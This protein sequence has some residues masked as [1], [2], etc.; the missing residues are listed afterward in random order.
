MNKHSLKMVQRIVA[1]VLIL[2]L[3]AAC[4]AGCGGSS[5]AP[6]GNNSGNASQ[7]NTNTAPA[8]NN[9]G[10]ASQG[11]TNT[12][13]A[14]NSNTIP[15]TGYKSSKE[16]ADL[17]SEA[18]AYFYGLPGTE[19]DAAKAKELYLKALDKGSPFAAYM[20][21]LLAIMDPAS[22]DWQKTQKEYETWS[23]LALMAAYGAAQ[24]TDPEAC[25]TI[26]L[27]AKD[28]K[29]PK[30]GIPYLETAAKTEGPYQVMAM[31]AMG[32][33]CQKIGGSEYNALAAEWFEKAAGAGSKRAVSLLAKHY[34]VYVADHNKAIEWYKKALDVGYEPWY[35]MAQSY[36]SLKDY[37]SAVDAYEKGLAAGNYTCAY[38]LGNMYYVGAGVEA[39]ASKAL[40]YYAIYLKDR[41]QHEGGN[42]TDLNEK[43]LRENINDM[44]SKGMVDKNTVLSIMGEGFLNQ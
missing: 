23:D 35:S 13:P 34:Q 30:D 32:E 26:G 27:I 19:A 36:T 42:Y 10:N 24:D 33:L 6:A 29:E 31:T 4:L 28:T 39:N 40:E 15:S 8:G 3:L 38:G 16:V 18:E 12:T 20:M 22:E 41:P 17:L 21:S 5:T 14:E 2:T 1:A 25:L 44:I 7:G 11:N 9:S 37:T 43:K